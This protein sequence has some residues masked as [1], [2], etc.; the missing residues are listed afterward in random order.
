MLLFFVL[1]ISAFISFISVIHI[2]K[3]ITPILFELATMKLNKYSTVIVN[4]AISQV[5]DDKIE[6]DSLFKI[7][8][9]KNGDIQMIDFDS[10]KVNHALNIATSVVLNSIKVLE[11][12]D[13]ESVVD[14]GLEE[15]EIKNLAKG[16]VVEI[17][18]GS[19]SGVTFFANF[20]PMLP[21]R[22]QYIGDVNSN[23]E[24]KVTSYGLNNALME[25]S[26]HLEMTA[27][28]Y[29]PFQTEVKT[30]D[31]TIPLVIKMINGTV[32]NYY[33]G[34]ISSNSNMYRSRD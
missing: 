15:S 10:T 23:I 21:I 14:D 17:P 24:T 4:K 2:S 6:I 32:P 34:T 31:C 19:A 12:G 28:I 13:V 20:G 1:L 25:I 3:R 30:I 7:V 8:K 16:I 27:Q 18:L 9:N 33:S 11:S 22:F 29:L 26:I 5:L